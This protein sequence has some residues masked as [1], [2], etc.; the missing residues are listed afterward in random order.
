MAQDNHLLP[1]IHSSLHF[2]LTKLSE[3][4]GKEERVQHQHKQQQLHQQ[5]KN[6]RKNIIII[7]IK[8]RNTLK[9]K[10]IFGN[11]AKQLKKYIDELK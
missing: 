10:I 4:P 7:V 11:N 1:S 5:G 6:L 3:K 2:S 8:K 9:L